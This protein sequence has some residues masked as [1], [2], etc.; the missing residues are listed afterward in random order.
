[1]TDFDIER[2]LHL[3][4]RASICVAVVIVVTYIV[5]LADFIRVYVNMSVDRYLSDFAEG[6]WEEACAESW[7]DGCAAARVQGR[8]FCVS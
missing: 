3:L 2:A 6:L 4:D 7:S 8:L 1:M 5:R